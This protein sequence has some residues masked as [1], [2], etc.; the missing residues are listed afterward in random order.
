VYEQVR[1]RFAVLVQTLDETQLTTVVTFTPAWTVRDVLA[2]LV[3]IAADLNAQRFPTDDD[4]GGV[5]WNDAQ[6]ASRSEATLDDLLVEWG[7]EGP[8]FAA[9][10]QLFGREME[11]HFVGDLVTH[12]L[13]VAETLHVPIELGDDAMSLALQ[14]YVAFVDE[15]LTELGATMPPAVVDLA[16]LDR[17][18]LLSARRPLSS[19]PG[20]D[21]LAGVYAGTGYTFP[22]D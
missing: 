12:V 1:T 15:R 16:P 22:T 9:G 8:I 14:H 6:V 18:R 5:A 21:V 20:A 11:C 13:D 17:L 4:P 7:R 19:V 2:H 3:G 10:L